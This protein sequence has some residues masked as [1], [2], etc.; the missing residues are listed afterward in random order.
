[1]QVE[2]AGKLKA[3]PQPELADRFLAFMLSPEFQSL[4]PAT[5]WMYPA[6]MPEAGLPEG[7]DAPL[8]PAKALFFSASD[9]AAKRDSALDEWL[10][11]L[12][13]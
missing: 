13:K 10:T 7:F 2:V 12:S 5:N 8:D 9:A 1:M 11:A 6:V 4:I 3:A